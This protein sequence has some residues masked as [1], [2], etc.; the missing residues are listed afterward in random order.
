MT[1]DR[2]QSEELRQALLGS[3]SDDLIRFI[4]DVAMDR[5]SGTTSAEILEVA[6]KLELVTPG[7]QVLTRTGNLL[8]DSLREYSFWQE[9]GQ[10]LPSEGEV[11]HL[12]RAYFSGKK[13]VEIGC[14][15]GCNLWSLQTVSQD[16]IGVEPEPVYP[17]IGE[18][19]CEREGIPAPEIKLGSAEALPLKDE[20][21]DVAICITSHQY[22]DVAAA[23]KEIV[24]ILR[25]GGEVLLVGGTLGTYLKVGSAQ[26][27][28]GSLRATKAFAIAIANTIF[29]SAT[30]RRLINKEERGTTAYPIYPTAGYM[31]RQLQRLGLVPSRPIDRIYP[32]TCFSYRKPLEHYRR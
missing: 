11:D 30:G 20:A 3:G 23:L 10:Q 4:V 1:L 5:N 13:V 9:R 19:L 21:F 24:R 27:R 15:A 7:T 31:K 26:I 25:P 12:S 32:E 2:T 28:R 8:A 14:G 22:M 6:E 16:G 18:I 29:Y 17:L